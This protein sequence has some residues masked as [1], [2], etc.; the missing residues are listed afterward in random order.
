VVDMGDD[1]EVPDVFLV[2]HTLCLQPPVDRLQ[3]IISPPPDVGQR[4][5]PTARGRPMVYSRYPPK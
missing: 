1:A 2:R 3:A 4:N 5:Q